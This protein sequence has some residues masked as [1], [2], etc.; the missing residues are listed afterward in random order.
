MLIR[1]LASVSPFTE[2]VSGGLKFKMVKYLDYQTQT[3]ENC[4]ILFAC[5]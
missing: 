5:S 1:N 2:V 4:S 3:E